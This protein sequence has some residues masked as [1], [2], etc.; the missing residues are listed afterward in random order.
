MYHSGLLPGDDEIKKFEEPRRGS[1]TMSRIT[2]VQV[3]DAT[4][5]D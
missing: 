1:I 5:V 3:C 4:A 2:E